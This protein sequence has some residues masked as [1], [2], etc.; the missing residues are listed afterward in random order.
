MKSKS[1]SNVLNV[2]GGIN[3]LTQIGTIK[4]DEIETE[5]EVAIYK[6][7]LPIAALPI[8]TVLILNEINLRVRKT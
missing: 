7:S 5:Y 3:E 1:Y 4:A 2:A 6:R 8:S